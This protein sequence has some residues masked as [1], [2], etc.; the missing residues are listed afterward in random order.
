[1]MA[2]FCSRLQTESLALHLMNFLYHSCDK[3]LIYNGL[4]TSLLIVLY[5][6]KVDV[7]YFTCGLNMSVLGT[8]M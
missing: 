4:H 5:K 3:L 2:V 1:M 8:T 7:A 6:V